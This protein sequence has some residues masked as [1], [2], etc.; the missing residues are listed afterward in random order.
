MAE[1]LPSLSRAL[2]PPYH[3]GLDK[4]R[5]GI[6]ERTLMRLQY[7]DALRK[8]GLRPHDK[9][10]ARALGLSLRQCQRIAAG[11]SRVP[12]PVAKLLRLALQRHV[13]SAALERL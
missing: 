9:S 7:L 8:L 13:K 4:T 11:E 1:V 12:G 6:E 3:R 5:E 10:T 2:E